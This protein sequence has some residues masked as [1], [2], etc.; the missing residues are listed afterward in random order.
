MNLDLKEWIWFANLRG[1]ITRKKAELLRIFDSPAEIYKLM[2][3]N[4]Q[5]PVC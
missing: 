5:R 3:L 2:L 4:W 1:I